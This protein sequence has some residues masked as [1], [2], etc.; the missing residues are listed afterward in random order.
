MIGYVRR[1]CFGALLA[2]ATIFAATPSAR[3]DVLSDA[4]K[5]VAGYAKAS[6]NPDTIKQALAFLAQYGYC[7]A[8][9]ADPE[10]DAMSGVLATAR[11]LNKFSDVSSCKAAIPGLNEMQKFSGYVPGI[12][13]LS[14]EFECACAVATSGVDGLEKVLKDLGEAT[15]ACGSVV[16]DIVEYGKDVAAAL[17]QA[18]ED[19]AKVGEAGMDMLED[20]LMMGG[21]F[22]D[23]VSSLGEFGEALLDTIEDT[24]NAIACAAS[25]GVIGCGDDHPFSDL[26]PQ[27][28]YMFC[29]GLQTVDGIIWDMMKKECEAANFGDLG[30]LGV[31]C[32]AG[33][34]CGGPQ[35]DTCLACPASV[36]SL[37]AQVIGGEGL[38]VVPG[39]TLD[40][41]LCGC[42]NGFAPNYK[43]TPSGPVLNACT[44]S[45][46]KQIIVPGCAAGD[47]ACINAGKLGGTALCGCPSGTVESG[48]TQ[49]KACPLGFEPDEA[50]HTCVPACPPGQIGTPGN[51]KACPPNTRAISVSGS[52]GACEACP[53]GT[54]ATAGS[55]ACVPLACGPT[56]YQDPNDPHACKLCPAGQAYVPAHKETLPGPTPG[57]SKT[58]EV[59][60][61]CEKLQ[62]PPAQP[63]VPNTGA[64]PLTPAP[65]L[66][67]KPMRPLRANCAAR[68]PLFINSPRNPSVCVRCP[69]GRVPNE[70]R[71]ACVGPLRR[72]PPPAIRRAPPRPLPPAMRRPLA[73]VPGVR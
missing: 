28:K 42:G 29:K 7:A 23:C 44:C 53:A 13:S 55:T 68:G 50:Q 14:Q 24:G 43:P 48:N 30:C 11:K 15:K 12:G 56:G 72:P 63:M 32:G 33:T 45:A 21:S 65:G 70:T 37:T 39:K 2:A 19:L 6:M 20:C 34:Q 69:P 17:E 5:C 57:Q 73:P 49:C 8:Y 3:A 1:I 62:L 61:H 18:G 36:N 59:A 52:L 41:G 31:S 26:T 27:Q 71:D 51:C 22:S 25:F 38:A 9:F 54:R 16:G 64:P 66:V 4:G 40:S 35:N 47:T 67:P 46:P 10:F 58:I 60:G